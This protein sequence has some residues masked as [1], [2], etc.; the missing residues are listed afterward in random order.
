[1]NSDGLQIPRERISYL[2]TTESDGIVDEPSLFIRTDPRAEGFLFGLEMLCFEDFLLGLSGPASFLTFDLLDPH[3]LRANQSCPESFDPVEDQPSGEKPIE[4]LGAFLL[5]FYV[6]AGRHVDEID[7]GRGFVDLLTAGAGGA[8]ERFPEFL[9]PDAE[10][11]HPLPE[12]R[13]FFLGQSHFF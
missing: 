7:A 11:L 1:L 4:S 3:L 10:V 9:F 6:K 8:D 2:L 13:L 5:A 12:R